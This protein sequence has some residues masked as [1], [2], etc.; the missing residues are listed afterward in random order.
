MAEY[1]EIKEAEKTA[2]L[3]RQEQWPEYSEYTDKFL[4]ATKTQQTLSPLE[5]KKRYSQSA[6]TTREG[7]AKKMD[8]TCTGEKQTAPNSAASQRPLSTEKL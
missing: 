8:D 7:T 2:R 3:A 1:E 4:L 6:K 5:E